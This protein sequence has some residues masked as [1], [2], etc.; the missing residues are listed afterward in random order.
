MRLLQTPYLLSCI[1]ILP[2]VAH[3]SCLW[4]PEIHAPRHGDGRISIA[5]GKSMVGIGTHERLHEIYRIL[6]IHP[7]GLRYQGEEYK[8]EQN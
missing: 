3:L 7:D 5:C 2:S 8:Y 1:G 4:N 6:Y